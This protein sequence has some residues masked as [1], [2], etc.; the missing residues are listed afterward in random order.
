MIQL[1]L[2]S[3]KSLSQFPEFHI[4]LLHDTDTN[5]IGFKFAKAKKNLNQQTAI[6][7]LL[8]KYKSKDKIVYSTIPLLLESN[9]AKFL[10]S[11]I[12]TTLEKEFLHVLENNFSDLLES[13]TIDFTDLKK[14]LNAF[15]AKNPFILT[16][17]DYNL[18]KNKEMSS[19]NKLKQLFIKIKKRGLCIERNDTFE[20]SVIQKIPKDFS[21]FL[22]D[23]LFLPQHLTVTRARMILMFLILLFFPTLKPKDLLFINHQFFLDLGLD[24]EKECFFIFQDRTIFITPFMK[25]VFSSAL[26]QRAIQIYFIEENLLYLASS[27]KNKRGEPSNKHSFYVFFFQALAKLDNFEGDGLA[28][29]QSELDIDNLEVLAKLDQLE[30]FDKKITLASFQ[31]FWLK[32]FSTYGDDYHHQKILGLTSTAISRQLKSY[33]LTKHKNSTGENYK[34]FVTEV[35]LIDFILKPLLARY[36][37]Y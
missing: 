19:S 37:L 30:S 33:G 36:F 11:G 27:F 9:S 34:I 1:I 32:N 10:S 26:I 17:P 18:A 2:F 31:F 7:S 14:K 8:S 21:P 15:F 24:L 25:K 6:N 12:A 4:L 5:E 22:L 28:Q 29:G 3:S 20:S 13:P 35:E 23:Q 16:N